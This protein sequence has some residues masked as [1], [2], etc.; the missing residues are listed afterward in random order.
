MK[1]KLLI[2][3]SVGILLSLSGCS[4]DSNERVNQVNKAKNEVKAE[5]KE[6]SITTVD[7][8][9]FDI[10]KSED[11]KSGVMFMPQNTND[12]W[13]LKFKKFRGTH[14]MSRIKLNKDQVVKFQYNSKIESGKLVFIILDNK[15]EIVKYVQGNK[16]EI[17]ELKAA[18][19]GEYILKVV[20]EDATDGEIVVKFK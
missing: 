5:S 4:K 8:S 20:G 6:N 11:E 9:K 15:G 17:I 14:T 2:V 19:E 16:E 12:S 3:L 1:R 10:T 7:L 18:E 13:E